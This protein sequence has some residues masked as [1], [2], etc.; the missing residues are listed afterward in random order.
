MRVGVL[1]AR[2]MVVGL[3]LVIDWSARDLVI[4]VIQHVCVGGGREEHAYADGAGVGPDKRGHR[5]GR[6]P[7]PLPSLSLPQDHG[8][9]RCQHLCL[10]LMPHA[11][12][13]CTMHHAHDTLPAHV[14]E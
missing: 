4:L 7:L 2:V 13:P 3:V 8:L 14:M 5:A 11:H 12:A 6:R 1:K 10:M 9:M